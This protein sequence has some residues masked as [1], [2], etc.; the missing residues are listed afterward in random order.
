VIFSYYYS[1]DHVTNDY[2][3]LLNMWEE[4]KTHYNMVHTKL[5]GNKKKDDEVDV[6]VI[7]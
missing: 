7:T 5:H 4:K 1:T 2:H 3:D 6:R